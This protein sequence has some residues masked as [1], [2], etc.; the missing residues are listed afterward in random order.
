MSWLVRTSRV[1]LRIEGSPSRVAFAFALGVFI[2]FTPILGIHTWIGLGLAI[3]FRLNKVA[4]LIGVWTNNPWTVGPML[5]AGTLVGCS[6]LGVSPASVS[7]IDWSLHG[8][9]FYASLFAG[10]RPLLLPY[11]VGN[12]VLGIAAGVVTFFVLRAILA[13]RRSSTET[14]QVA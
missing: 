14:A 10:V 7:R 12:L 8:S 9:A 6:L 1:L 11:V 13:R 3:V 2:A 4:V 5:T